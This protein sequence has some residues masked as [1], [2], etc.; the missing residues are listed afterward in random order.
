[1]CANSFSMKSI[2]YHYVR[3]Y[4][5]AFPFYNYLNKT[6]FAKQ[7]KKFEKI[8]LINN[9]NQLFKPSKK[10]LFSFD[11]GLKDHIFTAEMLK[12]SKVKKGSAV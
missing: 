11:D 10:I 9:Y 2:M 8:G 5:K 7:V 6:E 3:S 4:D 12:K 1:M